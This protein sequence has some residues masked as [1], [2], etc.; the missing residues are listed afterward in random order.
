MKIDHTRNGLP[1]QYDEEPLLFTAA[2]ETGLT[3]SDRSNKYEILGILRPLIVNNN[4]NIIL[5]LWE[6]NSLSAR[7]FVLSFYTSLYK[8]GNVKQSFFSAKLFLKNKYKNN[9][10]HYA[11]YYL[12]HSF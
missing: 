2:C 11:P 7:D 9:P 1:T 10:F 8:T 5:T 6:V 12:I 3:K 4:K